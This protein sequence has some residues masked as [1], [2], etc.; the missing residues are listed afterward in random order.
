[1]PESNNKIKNGKKATQGIAPGVSRRDQFL[2]EAAGIRAACLQLIA[3]SANISV[4]IKAAKD[5]PDVQLDE[6]KVGALANTLAN[7]L[8]VLK[9]ELDNLVASCDANIREITHTTDELTVMDITVKV[10]Q[11]YQNWQDRFIN[12]TAPTLEEI[13]ELCGGTGD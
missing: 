7:D 6:A 1:M 12:L 4:L 13:T 3:S 2:N 5:N 10:G 9:I 8:K 11:R